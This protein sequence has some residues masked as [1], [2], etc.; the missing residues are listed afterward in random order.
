MLLCAKYSFKALLHFSLEL[1]LLETLLS[2]VGSFAEH[3]WFSLEVQHQIRLMK[4][5]VCTQAPLI[6][7]TLCY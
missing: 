3:L 1:Q 5:F 2:E 7:H 4:A 6:V